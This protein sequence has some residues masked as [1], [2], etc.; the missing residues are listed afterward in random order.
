MTARTTPG[1][2]LAT[3][4]ATLLLTSVASAAPVQLP[5]STKTTLSNGLT[6][7]VMPV[8]RLPLVHFRLVARAGAASDPG[9]KEGLASLTAD[10]L[11]QGAAKR[12]AQQI[13][14]DIAFVGGEL[15]AGAGMEQLSV[16]CEV[17]TKDFATGLELFHD[18]IVRPTFPAEDFD[19]KKEEAL[20]AIESEKDDPATVAD[21]E[22]LPFLMGK[23]TLA[24]PP[25]GWAKSVEAITLED[26]VAFHR[27]FIRPDGAI[28]AVVGDVDAKKTVDALK[29]AFDDWKKPASPLTPPD[30]TLRITGREV[31][32]VNKPGATQTT[33]RFAG[34]GLRRD[35]PDYYAVLV[36]NTILGSG[37]TSR[38]M[39]EIRV[40]QGLTYSIRSNFAMYHDSGTFGIRTSTKNETIRKTIDETLR[41]MDTLREQGPKDE[42]LAKAK[43]YLTGLFPL[44]LQPLGGLA[45]QLTE[46]EMYRLDPKYVE[47]Y[48]DKI[49]AVTMEECRRVLK[50]Y[51]TTKDLKILLVTEGDVG[52]AAVDGLGPVTVKELGAP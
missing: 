6:V 24:H 30:E 1:A 11:T 38:L 16:R 35:H 51:F 28:L 50:S 5:P 39:D 3:A 43:S 19:R 48:A 15:A 4:L 45:G 31:M 7:F 14:E 17:L 34:P 52:K 41:V 10:L 36:A 49:N 33:L 26:V 13:A 27:D 42:E 46:I 32:I 25:I 2:R 22:L 12:N 20:G 44:A 21:H 47:T 9:G 37:F 23:S 18:V 29:K 40:S 8:K